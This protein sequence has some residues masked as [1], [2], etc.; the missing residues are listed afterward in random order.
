MNIYSKSF[1]GYCF[2][3]LIVAL[4][5]FVEDS[6]LGLSSH[7]FLILHQHYWYFLVLLVCIFWSSV[8]LKKTFAELYWFV[9]LMPV[10][11]LAMIFVCFFDVSISGLVY[12]NGADFSK[13]MR[14]TAT[15]LLGHKEDLPI[16]IELISIFVAT[17]F[18]SLIVT[19]SVWKSFANAVICHISVMNI[20]TLYVSPS[21]KE[22]LFGILTSIDFQMWMAFKYMSYAFIMIFVLFRHEIIGFYK[23]NRRFRISGIILFASIESVF[24]ALFGIR[25]YLQNH[26][27][28][29]ADIFVTFV[30]SIVVSQTLNLLF[31]TKIKDFV[32]RKLFLAFHSLIIFMMILFYLTGWY[33]YIGHTYKDSTGMKANAVVADKIPAENTKKKSIEIYDTIIVGGGLAGLKAAND[34]KDY[35]ILLLEKE[36]R[37]GGRVFTER[38][39]KNNSDF[40][41]LGALFGFSEELIPEGFEIGEKIPANKKYGIYQN[42]KFY[43]NR[44]VLSA[45]RSIEPKDA[46]FFDKY[47]KPE[48][49]DKLFQNVSDDSKK[50]LKAAFN[51]IHPGNFEEYTNQR[52]HNALTT[53]KFDQYVGGN[54]SLIEAYGE[55][56]NNRFLLNSEVTSVESKD[57]IITIRYNKAGEPKEIKAKSVIVATPSGVA[58]KIIKNMNKNAEIFLN[59]VRYGKGMAVVFEVNKNN[60]D[61]FAYLITPDNSFNTVFFNNTADGKREVLTLYFIDS[62]V[63]ANPNLQPEDYI[64]IAKEELYKIGIFN[65]KTEFFYEKARFW[66]DLGTIIT[67]YYYGFTEEALNPA[68][69]I[70]LAGDYTFYN[71]DENP[72]GLGAAFF[73]GEAAAERVVKYLNHSKAKKKEQKKNISGNNTAQVRFSENLLSNA[74]QMFDEKY[75]LTHCSRYKIVDEKPEFID[76]FDEG[77]IAL[78]AL[79]AQAA[80]DRELAHKVADARTDDFQWEYGY[81]YGGTSFD[82]SIVLES[83]VS[84]DVDRETVGKSLESLKKIY[85]RKDEG[86]FTTLPENIGR[87]A[88]WQGCSADVTSHLGWIF[89]KFDPEKYGELVKNCAEYVKNVINSKSESKFKSKWFPSNFLT[90]YYAARLLG[91]F[92]KKY[93]KE[94][95]IIEKYLMSKQR[96]NGSFSDS[97]LET[98]YA[99][100]SMKAIENKELLSNIEKAEFWLRNNRNHYPEPILYYWIDSNENP[101]TKIFFSCYDKGLISEAY[102]KMALEK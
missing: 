11:F 74:S 37:L 73:S 63:S 44:D 72:Y 2:L 94:L 96:E 4:R 92:G 23:S 45:L 35:N 56:I 29:F 14:Y 80:N 42:G 26:Y 95:N 88:Y 89:Y 77:N 15:F 41:E 69:G 18:Y 25:P 75:N 100:L 28:Y 47:D 52:K 36:N 61:N 102:K 59:S 54:S 68:K 62:F 82:S 87:S 27:F 51:V 55:A 33:L 13:N 97:V 90:P 46:R 86:C 66:K 78:Y 19:K 34:L 48:D 85:F 43:K 9:F 98:S 32:F 30:P 53:F 57:G 8:F 20:G 31:F 79:I 58:R 10:I 67:K 60:P 38:C 1:L 76:T 93:Q 24:I 7:F 71:E 3:F 21:E 6:I 16:S 84:L 64:R 81:G 39:G 70:Y 83:L 12:L 99:V 65:E 17:L 5:F 91:I 22:S 101:N 40:C 49:I 50:A